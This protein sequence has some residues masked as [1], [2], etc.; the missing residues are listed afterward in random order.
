MSN[1]GPGSRNPCQEEI[2]F[3][4]LGLVAVCWAIWKARNA[5]C[6]DKKMI[7]NPN[8][9]IFSTC[10]FMG[11]DYNRKPPR[12]CSMQVLIQW[13]RPVAVAGKKSRGASFEADQGWKVWTRAGRR[14]FPRERPRWRWVKDAWL[15]VANWKSRRCLAFASYD[16]ACSFAP[17]S[18]LL[19]QLKRWGVL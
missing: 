6:F 17:S 8:K 1:I 13:W 15:R 12:S 18:F 9:I 7:K 3:R 5:A 19:K 10:L 16:V 14:C 2:E 11:Q 4:L